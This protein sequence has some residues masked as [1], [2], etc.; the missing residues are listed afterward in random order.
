MKDIASLLWAIP[1]EESYI[2]K[3][4]PEGFDELRTDHES[5]ADLSAHFDGRVVDGKKTV[6]AVQEHVD[7]CMSVQLTTK[8]EAV[9]KEIDGE[10]QTWMVRKPDIDTMRDKLFKNKVH[11]DR[12]DKGNTELDN[13][14]KTA[15]NFAKEALLPNT[16]LHRC[17]FLFTGYRRCRRPLRNSTPP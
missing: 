5:F 17:S 9:S 13:I 10:W 11:W 14:I 16:Q 12:V 6:S 2:G 8:L 15:E 3:V 4:S 7:Q 1:A